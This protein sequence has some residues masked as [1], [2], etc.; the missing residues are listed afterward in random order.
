MLFGSAA[1]C[2]ILLA[3]SVFSS[4]R[5]APCAWGGSSSRCAKPLAAPPLPALDLKQTFAPQPS[6]VSVD[7]LRKKF[8]IQVKSVKVCGASGFG[9]FAPLVGNI[10]VGVSATAFKTAPHERALQVVAGLLFRF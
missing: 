1:L 10:G 3:G 6:A 2:A 8:P 5:P 7:L 9:V 4:A